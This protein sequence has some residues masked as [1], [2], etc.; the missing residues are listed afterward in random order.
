MLDQAIV[1]AK[2]EL[3]S[4]GFL[5]K[6]PV[7]DDLDNEDD[8]PDEIDEPDDDVIPYTSAN[9]KRDLD[10]EFDSDRLDDQADAEDDD[11]NEDDDDFGEEYID[12]IEPW[13]AEKVAIMAGVLA[14]IADS[15][16][17]DTIMTAFEEGLIDESL[18]P[19]DFVLEQYDETGEPTDEEADQSWLDAYREDYAA[20]MK[21]LEPSAPSSTPRAKYRYEDRY[22]EGDPPPT[23]S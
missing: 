17:R 10:G 1:A 23:S 21:S 20:H 11:R 12:P 14:T 6:H 19:R 3:K 5:E 13:A 18:L 15:S 4:K 16:S 8:D 2:E 7:Y 9:L 22:D